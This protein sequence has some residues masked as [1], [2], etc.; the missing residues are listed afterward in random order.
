MDIQFN[1]S[2]SFYRTYSFYST[3]SFYSTLIA[4]LFLLQNLFL[5][6]YL[7][8]LQYLDSQILMDAHQSNFDLF[9]LDNITSTSQI[10]LEVIDF[11]ISV[12]QN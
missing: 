3:C 10:N 11:F 2:Y 1:K 7:F 4:K 8:I 9:D 6:Q 12:S 5:L